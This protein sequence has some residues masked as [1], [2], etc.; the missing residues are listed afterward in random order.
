[1]AVLP[2]A[3][4]TRGST[5]QRSAYRGAIQTVGGA[6]GVRCFSTCNAS[7]T[8]VSSWGSRPAAQSCGATPFLTA[9]TLG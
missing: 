7:R 4:M 6:A 1:M 8:A 9:E 2:C 3:E 5:L